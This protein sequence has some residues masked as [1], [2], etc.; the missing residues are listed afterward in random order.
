[1]STANR[2]TRR[3][4]ELDGRLS[5]LAAVCEEL[6]HREAVPYAPD[7]AVAG[8]RGQEH[9]LHR[10]VQALHGALEVRGVGG[11]ILHRHI[12]QIERGRHRPSTAEGQRVAQGLPH[13]RPLSYKKKP[14]HQNTPNSGWGGVRLNG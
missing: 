12:Q 8:Q 7:Q 3:K 6:A 1:M 4:S 13:P 9:V 5:V 11:Q 10:P 14:A 2:A